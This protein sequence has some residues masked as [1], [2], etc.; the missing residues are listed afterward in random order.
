MAQ[1]N[2]PAAPP[3]DPGLRVLLPD[4]TEITVAPVT[5]RQAQRALALYSQDVAAEKELAY[6]TRLIHELDILLGPEHDGLAETLSPVT[7]IDLAEML[8]FEAAECVPL[9]YRPLLPICQR[10]MKPAAE[11]L[12]TVNALAIALRE[13]FFLAAPQVEQMPLADAFRLL[14][15]PR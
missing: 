13:Q 4:D 7:A 1:S 15:A 10:P 12:A 14:N 5:I 9:A 8:W 6:I 11:L 3:P 2:L